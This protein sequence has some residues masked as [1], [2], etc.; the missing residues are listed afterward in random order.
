MVAYYMMW[1]RDITN[2]EA[3]KHYSD[4][5]AASVEFYGGRF[6]SL[7]GKLE[8]ADGADLDHQVIAI[9]F[10]S[11]T[12]AREWYASSRYETARSLA[13]MLRGFSSMFLDSVSEVG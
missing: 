7:C 5:A 10:P 12:I 13:S 8:S 9:E 4:Q 1:N 2:P 11:M 3:L 6:A